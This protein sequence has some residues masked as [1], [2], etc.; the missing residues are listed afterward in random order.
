VIAKKQIA[1]LTA[2]ACLALPSAAQAEFGFVPGGAT[3]TAI[4]KDGTIDTKAGSHPYAFTTHFEFK[5]EPDG[6]TQGGETRDAEVQL[7]PGFFGNPQALP[8]CPQKEFEGGLPNCSPNTQIG[9]LRAILPGF[10]E[11]KGAVFNV[12]PPHG[13][14]GELAFS[15]GASG[16]VDLQF[17]SV[18]EDGS[19]GLTVT[20]PNLPVGI[21]S[22]TETIWGT[23]ADSGHDA[24]RGAENAEGT[25]SGPIASDAPQSPYL[26]MP[27][28]CEGVPT[29]LIR[30]D[31]VL[32]PGNFAEILAP[33]IDS[34]G[35][36]VAMSSCESVPFSPQISVQPTTRLT[37]NPSGLDFS[38]DLPN[39]GLL[40]KEAIAET[41]PK[42]VQV[43]LPEG[44]TVN[45]SLAEGVGICSEAQF[46]AEKVNTPPGAGCPQASKLGSVVAHTP[47]LE[48]TFE[49]AVY[50]AAPYDN[51][52]GTLTAL[53]LVVRAPGAGVIVKQAGR[54]DFDPDTGQITTTFDQ[55]PPLP[56]S[57]FDFHFKEG[58]RSPLASPP[59]CGE[60]VTTA[61]MTPFSAKGDAEA[62]T[63]TSSFT[64]DHGTEG[65]A[66]PTGGLPP[67]RPGLIAGSINNAAGRFSP[68]NVRLFRTDAE[69]E[70][71]RFSIKLP[72]GVVGKLAG[73][74]FCPDAAIA[75]AKARTGIHGGEEEINSPSCPAASEIGHSLAGAGVGQSLA[76]APGKLYLAGPYHGSAISLV[77]ITAAKVG[78]F[79]LGT[80]VIRQ[81]FKIDPETG[82]VF[83]DATGSDP[84][85][86]IIKGVTVHARDIRAYTDRPQFVLNPSSCKRTSTAS[87]LLGSGLDFS[88]EADDRPVTVSTP[89]Q[90]AD[91]AALPFKP[92]LSL[93]LKGGTRR[94]DYPALNAVLNMNGIGEAGIRRAQVTL[95][96][97][98]FIA[99][100][101]FN[102][103][104]TRV[105]FKQGTHP[106]EKCPTGSIY[107]KAT[108]ETP[109][110]SE[111]LA[112]PVF[113]RSSEHQL[114][115]VVAA[116]HNGEI[117][118]VL[119]G[120]V[121]SVK[122]RLRNTFEATPDA[123]VK[124]VVVSLMGGKKGLF[125]NSTDLCAS[126]HKAIASFT[127]HNGKL[128]EFNPVVKAT[129]CGKAK[130]QK[131]KRRAAGQKRK[132]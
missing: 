131:A 90:A 123:P 71:T 22:V 39:Q 7:P 96:R 47:L 70:F 56:Y 95:P 51:P 25:G 61:K 93:K 122:G 44:M 125:E 105:V 41:E 36:P 33:A 100:A 68:F 24:E 18:R 5:T 1:L 113:L 99:N 34:G 76:Y 98:E 13:I 127:G 101:H 88:S 6:S 79:D 43:T 50:L 130:K 94:G 32:D 114:P 92:R 126:T 77:A 14:A 124:R 27:A 3:V 67:F 26:T 107:G 116:L 120:R 83:I 12:V 102:T 19:Y 74:P 86:H 21:S 132:G 55:L 42:R 117:D 119:V 45:P 57:S 108:A 40:D 87:T 46:K 30:A 91:C 15:S 63:R 115:D 60:Y 53:Y 8:K 9:V 48:E 66:C 128:H 65:G 78:P 31:S 103:I 73:V 72:P 80:V 111:P 112:G 106:G 129:G 118:V 10:G 4:N 29:S 109:L 69:Q 75:A 58:A 121:D 38:L 28:S 20:A 49:G 104:C 85:P 52:F 110:L 35:N 64:I 37:E 16:L 62:V 54:V 82:E 89:F 81:A 97:S 11:T 59:A 84:I 23:P 17:A 2:L